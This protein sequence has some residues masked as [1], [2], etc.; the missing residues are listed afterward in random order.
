M[1]GRDRSPSDNIVS[2]GLEDYQTK[3]NRLNAALNSVSSN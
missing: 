1:V 2:F 3:L